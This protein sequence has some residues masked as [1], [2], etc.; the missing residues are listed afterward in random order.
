MKLLMPFRFSALTNH[1]SHARSIRNAS[2]LFP[3][4]LD[5]NQLLDSLDESLELGDEDAVREPAK[6]PAATSARN[7]DSTD[8]SSEHAEVATW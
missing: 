7:T 8:G 6:A 2:S 5:L 3:D 4:D 1:P